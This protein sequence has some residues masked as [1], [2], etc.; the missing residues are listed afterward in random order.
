LIGGFGL[1]YYLAIGFRDAF[2][3]SAKG[4]QKANDQWE[5]EGISP[6]DSIREDIVDL[7]D[8]AKSK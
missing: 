8:S 1:Y 4:L 5:Q 6:I 3:D 2:L 7:I